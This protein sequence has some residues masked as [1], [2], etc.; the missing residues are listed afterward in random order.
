MRAESFQSVITNSNVIITVLEEIM[1]E[2]KGNFEACC[3][4]RGVLTTMENYYFLFGVTIS[5]KV[6]PITDKLSKALQIYQ[7]LLLKILHLLQ[8]VV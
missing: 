3:Q 2:Y 4:A 8:Y 6:F 1:D 7:Q 5:E